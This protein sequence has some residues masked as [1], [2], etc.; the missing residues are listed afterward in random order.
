[1]KRKHVA[2]GAGW[3]IGLVK[4]D[5]FSVVTSPTSVVIRD[6]LPLSKAC[7][8]LAGGNAGPR[9]RRETTL[10]GSY[11]SDTAH[12]SHGAVGAHSGCVPG[13]QEAEYSLTE[14]GVDIS[15]ETMRRRVSESALVLEG[16]GPA[17]P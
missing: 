8:S 17:G 1:M 6:I 11:S 3:V 10:G 7:H 13:F 15:H 16:Q 5:V 2:T 4:D 12:R 14:R 9:A